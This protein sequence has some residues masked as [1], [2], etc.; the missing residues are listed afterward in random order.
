MSMMILTALSLGALGPCRSGQERPALERGL[1]LGGL[2]LAGTLAGAALSALCGVQRSRGGSVLAFAALTFAGG[3][4][5][6]E[7][8]RPP[9]AP[10]RGTCPGAVAVDALLVGLALP[11]FPL[12]LSHAAALM[13][14]AAFALGALS[15]LL[16]EGL[17]ERLHPWLNA[18]GGLILT[19]AGMQPLLHALL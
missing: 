15:A 13:G 16:P 9:E 7:A 10:S 5:L 19:C 4:M 11:C 17:L 1:L 6:L 2:S 3:R 18:A 12:R 8:V 14:G